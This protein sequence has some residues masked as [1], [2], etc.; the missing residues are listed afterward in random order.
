MRRL[1]QSHQPRERSSL[2]GTQEVIG[3]SSL[4]FRAYDVSTL[5]ELLREDGLARRGEDRAERVG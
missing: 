5:S 2:F 1:I 4:Q 3:H